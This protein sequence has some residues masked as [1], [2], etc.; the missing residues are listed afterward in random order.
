MLEY[1]AD[2]LL[3]TDMQKDRVVQEIYSVL[4]QKQGIP[5]LQGIVTTQI[6][7]ADGASFE[8]PGY[9]DVGLQDTMKDLALNLVGAALF[10]VMGYLRLSGR[11]GAPAERLIPRVEKRG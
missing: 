8:L 5:A 2:T 4:L 11:G 7:T 9:L 10:C 6:R 1:A 3:H